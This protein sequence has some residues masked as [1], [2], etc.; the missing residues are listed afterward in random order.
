MKANRSS[1]NTYIYIFPHNFLTFL[2]VKSFHKLYYEQSV[3]Y[4]YFFVLAFEVDK[5][6]CTH[7]RSE[8]NKED[9]DLQLLISPFI[10]ATKI[11]GIYW[12]IFSC[13]ISVYS[14][15]LFSCWYYYYLTETTNQ[16]AQIQTE[17]DNVADLVFF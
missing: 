3:K 11:A 16:L 4:E 17:F 1:I 8:N 2:I 12:V 5:A 7:T 14:P 10:T 9:D 6:T 15:I 13:F